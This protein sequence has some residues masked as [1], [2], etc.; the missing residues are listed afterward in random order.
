MRPG[1]LP[2]CP[3]CGGYISGTFLKLCP[4]ARE[5]YMH[6]LCKEKGAYVTNDVTT[7]TKGVTEEERLTY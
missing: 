7:V 1:T 3:D 6:E 2:R 4:C 5:K